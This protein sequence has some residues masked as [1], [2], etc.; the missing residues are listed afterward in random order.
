MPEKRGLGEF[1]N[2]RGAWQER[3]GGSVFE[4]EGWYPNAHYGEESSP[5]IELKKKPFASVI[6][7]LFSISN[8]HTMTT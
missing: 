8:L 2:L 1:A 5:N 7:L 6:Y 3:G 4:G